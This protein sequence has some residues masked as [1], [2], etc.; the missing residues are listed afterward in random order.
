VSTCYERGFVARPSHR[1]QLSRGGSVELNRAGHDVVYV[2]ELGVQAASDNEIFDR[3]TPRAESSPRRPPIS[4]TLLATRNETST[5]VILFRHGSQHRPANQAELL[6]HNLPQLASA[7][8]NGSIVVIQP[9]RIRIRALP[10]LPWRHKTA[11]RGD[12]RMQLLDAYW[13]QAGAV[14]ASHQD[15]SCSG[16]RRSDGWCAGV[17]GLPIPDWPPMPPP[18]AA[19]AHPDTHEAGTVPVA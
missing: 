14:T 9:D 13:G 12:R 3:A 10:P 19:D 6:E 7:L 11:P 15:Q 8:E 1:L 16:P 4:E 2:R 5:S 18:A 17:R